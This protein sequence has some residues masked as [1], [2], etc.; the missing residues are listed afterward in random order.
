[1]DIYE[2]DKQDAYRFARNA[3]AR[4]YERG[5][6]LVFTECPYCHGGQHR[7]KSTFSINTKTGQFQCKRASCGVSGNM[8]TIARD[9]D[10]S[11]GTEADRYINRKEEEFRFRKFG[12]RKVTVTDPAI[13]YLKNR[14]ISED[15]AKKYRIASQKNADNIIVFP[16]FDEEGNLVTVK[17]RKADFNPETDRNK[18]WFEKGCKPILFGIEQ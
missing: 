8:L 16:F 9:F 4:A 1:M 11:L 12:K 15:V 14:G 2:F 5:D 3:G 17:Y 13:A 6:E 7:D 10:F 18:E